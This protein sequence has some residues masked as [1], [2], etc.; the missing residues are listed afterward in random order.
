MNCEIKLIRIGRGTSLSMWGKRGHYK[1]CGIVMSIVIVYVPS[2]I[3]IDRF[4]ENKCDGADSKDTTGH[5]Y[6]DGRLGR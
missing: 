1:G 4:L 2:F 6:N 3:G 5:T